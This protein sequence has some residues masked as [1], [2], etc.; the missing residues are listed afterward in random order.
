MTESVICDGLNNQHYLTFLEKKIMCLNAHWKLEKYPKDR[1]FLVIKAYH[2]DD[3][4]RNCNNKFRHKK[5]KYFNQRTMTNTEHNL[6]IS[7]SFMV[8]YPLKQLQL[9]LDTLSVFFS[10]SVHYLFPLISF[11]SF[12]IKISLLLYQ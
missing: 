2:D 4:E 5:C 1:G 8:V 10:I 6:L 12:L 3:A 7:S 11:S 9:C